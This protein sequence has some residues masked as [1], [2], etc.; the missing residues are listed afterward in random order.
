MHLIINL[1]KKKNPRRYG[2]RKYTHSDWFQGRNHCA[3]VNSLKKKEIAQQL[4][5]LTMN[6]SI[7]YSASQVIFGPDQVIVAKCTAHKYIEY[8]HKV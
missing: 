2:A 5:T 6:Q 7:L 4:K 8:Y 3:L 1:L